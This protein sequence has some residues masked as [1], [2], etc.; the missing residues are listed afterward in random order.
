[1]SKN[2]WPLV[3]L[4]DHVDLLSG[5]AFKSKQFTNDPQAIPLVKGENVH[6]GFIDWKIAKRWPSAMLD[7]C[8][9]YFL[10]PEDIVLAMD[11]PLIEAVLKWAWLRPEHPKAL[12]VQRVSRM[13]GLSEL[14]TR[15]LR[16]IIGSQQ[17]TDY[18]R[19]IVTGVNVRKRSGW[20]VAGGELAAA[21]AAL[22]GFCRACCV[23][24]LPV[25]AN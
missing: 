20:L 7:G 4:G 9:K 2:E 12:L 23:F 21:G 15:F 22:F 10:E 19:P 11:R 3:K 14:E 17:F 16:Y 5:F 25:C 8:E 18:I 24:K 13:R 6:Q 1:M